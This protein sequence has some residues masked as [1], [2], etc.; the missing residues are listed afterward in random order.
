[1]AHSALDLSLERASD[2]PL[3]TQLAWKLRAAI[4][5]GSLRPGDRLPGVRELATAA[6]VN[7][8]TARAVYAR[9]AKRGV[10][11]S[12]HGRGTFV[13]DVTGPGAG[14]GDLVERVA[15]D[16]RRHEVDPRELAALLYA[17]FDR[18]PLGPALDDGDV[19][20]RRALRAEIEALEHEL[21]ALE[22]LSPPVPERERSGAAG[23]RLVS[24]RELESTRDALARRV[25]GRRR[26]LREARAAA[27]TAARA[28]D[29]PVSR[30]S[31]SPTGAWPEL[32]AS[33]PRQ[34]RPAT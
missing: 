21:V 20:A 25:A 13:G 15:Q 23:A 9:L 33:L 12:E 22:P 27:R 2:V 4:A 31:L 32:M 17:R 7:V 19:E 26:E 18:A 6:G 14:I 24:V 28:G 5:S 8:N 29:R 1:M 34:P 11:V 30:R 3:G 10:I 16:A